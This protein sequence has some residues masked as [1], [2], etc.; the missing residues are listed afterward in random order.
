MENLIT[1][2]LLYMMHDYDNNEISDSD[3]DIDDNDIDNC[4]DDIAACDDN[5]DFKE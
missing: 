2:L 1:C 5:N 3:I 4:D